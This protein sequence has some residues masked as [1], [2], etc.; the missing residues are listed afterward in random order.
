MRQPQLGHFLQNMPERVRPFIAIAR[1]VRRAA[2][3]DAIENQNQGAH[4]LTR[5]TGLMECW[6]NGFLNGA[7]VHYSSLNFLRARWDATQFSSRP[8]R[9]SNMGSPPRISPSRP[10]PGPA[11]N[12][13]SRSR[14]EEHTSELQSQS[15]L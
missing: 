15:N 13:V 8:C 5:G 12:S 7:S 11:E 14:S 4:R 2:D 10:A 6:S 9:E 1:C 3:T